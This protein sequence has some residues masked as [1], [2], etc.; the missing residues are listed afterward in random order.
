MT[1]EG[2]KEIRN[3]LGKYVSTEIENTYMYINDV[4]LPMFLK[5]MQIDNHY[6]VE[7]RGIWE[8]ENDYMG[9]PF[10]SYTIHNPESNELLYLDGFIH[11]PGREKRNYMQQL[12]KIFTSCSLKFSRSEKIFTSAKF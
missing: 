1:K 6:A 4:D 11:A 9:G 8:I 2:I 3:T 7:A 12:E 5:T 10:I